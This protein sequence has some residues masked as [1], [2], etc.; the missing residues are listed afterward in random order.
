MSILSRLDAKFGRYAVP[1]LTVIIIIGQ[2]LM[3]VAQQL[4]PGKQGFHLL[5]RIRMYPERV[6][7]GEYWRVVTFLFDPPI[8]NL[9][10]AALFWYFLYL[11]G[12]TLEVTWGSFRY[13][14]YLLIGYVGSIACAFA[15]MIRFSDARGPAPQESHFLQKSSACGLFAR[16]AATIF[17]AYSKT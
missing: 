8:T 12:T 5:E 4:N 16:V 6:L 1:N 15:A 10:F 13:N 7:A 17:C 11:M 9:I 2:V 14:V 3:Y